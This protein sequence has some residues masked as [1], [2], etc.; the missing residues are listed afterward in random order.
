M[1]VKPKDTEYMN[2][3]KAEKEDWKYEGRKRLCYRRNFSIK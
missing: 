3:N 1:T 2:K